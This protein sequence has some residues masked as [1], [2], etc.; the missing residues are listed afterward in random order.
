QWVA[1]REGSVCETLPDESTA[2][3]IAA[4]GLCQNPDARR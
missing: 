4:I 1:M 3:R 2:G